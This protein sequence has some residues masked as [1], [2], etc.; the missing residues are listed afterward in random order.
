MLPLLTVILTMSRRQQPSTSRLIR[1]LPIK[2]LKRPSDPKV[3]ESTLL[4]SRRRLPSR[5]PIWTYKV[6]LTRSTPFNGVGHQRQLALRRLKAGQP[7]KKTWSV[8]PMRVNLL[9]AAFQSVVTVTRYVS[10]HSS[11]LILSNA[12]LCKAR[13]YSRQVS[14]RQERERAS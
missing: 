5:T 14:T 1:M 13:S 12:N 4:P 6:I 2:P 7:Q 9:I 3:L 10:T 8:W 11:P